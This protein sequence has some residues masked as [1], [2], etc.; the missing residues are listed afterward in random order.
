MYFL[1]FLSFLCFVA[2][3]VLKHSGGLR[4]IQ[5]GNIIAE[6]MSN[7]VGCTIREARAILLAAPTFRIMLKAGILTEE[8]AIGRR[9]NNQEIRKFIRPFIRGV[10]KQVGTEEAGLVT[11]KEDFK[12]T[13]NCSECK[14]NFICP[15]K[16]GAFRKSGI[17]SEV[18]NKFEEALKAIPQ[19]PLLLANAG[20]WYKEQGMLDEALE[21]Y[22]KV[23]DFFNSPDIQ[24]LSWYDRN[25]LLIPAYSISGLIY[26]EK[27]MKNK[28]IDCFKEILK[29][30]PK[31]DFANKNIEKLTNVNRQ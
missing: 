29:I 27:N 20:F 24:S 4:S 5:L 15:V 17:Y 13:V 22:R 12:S 14:S 19:C 26:E 30:D 25:V 8:K 28:A 23:I 16:T 9:L 18:I 7:Q 21:Q 2:Y 3:I 31:N 11:E 1:I 10:V 6:E